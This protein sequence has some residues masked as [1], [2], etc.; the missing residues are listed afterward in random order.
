MSVF[1]LTDRD[2]CTENDTCAANENCVNT[3]GSYS[4]NC[5]PGYTGETGNCQGYSLCFLF[6]VIFAFSS[7]IEDAIF[8]LMY[9][10]N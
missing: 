3:I 7:L 4:C 5:A 8:F 1:S 10:K 2:E 6:F 9:T